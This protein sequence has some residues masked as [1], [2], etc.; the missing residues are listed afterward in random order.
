M[1]TNEVYMISRNI[2]DAQKWYYLSQMRSDEM[3]VFKIFD[4]NSEVAQFGAHTAFTN[5]SM[6]KMDVEQISIEVRCLVVY[7]Q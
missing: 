3:F 6:S 2:Q 7:D 5:E 4:S 1:A